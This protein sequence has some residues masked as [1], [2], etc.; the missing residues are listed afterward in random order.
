LMAILILGVVMAAITTMI[1]QSFDV[2]DSSTR[3]MSAGQLAELGLSEVGGYLRTA[4]NFEHNVNWKFDG[5]HPE[6]DDQNVKFELSL[7][8][9]SLKL[10]VTGLNERTILNNVKDFNINE[11]DGDFIINIEVE[12]S[13]GNTA[14]K[15]LTVRSRN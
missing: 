14:N 12:D 1:V 10:N 3:R 4:T 7:D 11:D 8:N 13:E 5:Y 15:R 9:E 2:F 6:T